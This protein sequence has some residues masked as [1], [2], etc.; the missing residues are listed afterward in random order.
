MTAVIQLNSLT[1]NYGKVNA[2]QGV[3]LSIE[4]GTIFGFL[5]PNGA[6]KSTT[7]RILMGFIKPTSGTA[8]VFGL[9]SWQHST[10]LKARI[11]FVPDTIR[12]GKSFTGRSFLDY[13]ARLRGITGIPILQKELLDQLEMP[14]QVLKRKLHTYSSGMAKKIALIQAIQHK[15]DVMIFDEPTE[16]LDPIARKTL[17]TF[18]NQLKHEGST[19]LMSSHILPDVQE[20]C[21]TISLIKNGHI[22]SEGSVDQLRFGKSRNMTVEFN[23]LPS[24]DPAISGVTVVSKDGNTWEFNILHNL[25]GMLKYLV[26][27]DIVDLEYQ[28]LSLENLFLSAYEAHDGEEKHE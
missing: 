12:F 27:Q 28:Q 10:A 21:E 5:G 1:K 25:Q 14:E 22:E 19:I 23:K 17:F 18:M 16:A 6:G 24:S 15:P 7:I 13:T 2:L 9:D 20:I 11:G 26:T 4:S 3:N 8:T